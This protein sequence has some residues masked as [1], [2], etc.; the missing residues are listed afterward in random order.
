LIGAAVILFNPDSDVIYQLI[1]SVLQQV[2]ELYVNDNST[3]PAVLNIS[4][5][6]LHY[7]HF[8]NN[9]G[10]A[11]AHNVGLRDLRDSNCKYALLLDQVSQIDD[12]V[13]ELQR[14]I[15]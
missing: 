3:M 9:I 2:D 5:E 13:G 1:Q 11:A 14:M 6:K 4:K 15:T 7:H 10:I 12:D 8:P